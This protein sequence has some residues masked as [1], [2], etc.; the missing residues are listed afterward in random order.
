MYCWFF[1]HSD[2][3]LAGNIWIALVLPQVSMAVAVHLA[4]T[5]KSRK[6]KDQ[7]KREKLSCGD[8][9][10]KSKRGYPWRSRGDLH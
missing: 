8:E 7:S 10:D 2:I 6:N 9:S 1:V 4:K 3:H 5:K